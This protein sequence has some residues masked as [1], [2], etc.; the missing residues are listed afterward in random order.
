MEMITDMSIVLES[1]YVCSL[2][3]LSGNVQVDLCEVTLTV[4]VINNAIFNYTSHSF[5]SLCR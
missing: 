2:Y 4:N 1:R 5:F 3:L